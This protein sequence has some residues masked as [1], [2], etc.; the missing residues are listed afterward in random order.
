MRRVRLQRTVRSATPERTYLRVPMETA[1]RVLALYQ[2]TYFDL[3]VQHFH[4]K[5]REEHAIELSY[6]W[7][8]QAL[9]GARRKKRGSH[10]RRRPRKSIPGMQLHIA[11]SKHRWFAD[12]RYYDLLVILDD[13]TSEIY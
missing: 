11:G 13:A 3:S 7:V 5:L 4:E 9:Q 6:T 12:D 8:K 2:G 10:R 1:E